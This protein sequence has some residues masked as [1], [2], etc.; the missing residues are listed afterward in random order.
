MG[1]RLVLWD[2]GM[3]LDTQLAEAP[4][5]Q[6]LWNAQVMGRPEPRARNEATAQ[7]DKRRE[8][9]DKGKGERGSGE[10]EESSHVGEG[11]NPE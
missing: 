9:A 11:K 10:A 6:E 3:Y 2:K 4:K 1:R 7:D 5:M 8:E